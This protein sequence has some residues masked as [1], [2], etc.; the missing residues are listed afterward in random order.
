M[1]LFQLVQQRRRRIEII[2]QAAG[3][4]FI[5]CPTGCG[6]LVRISRL[7][8][9][10][11]GHLLDERPAPEN[12]HAFRAVLDQGRRLAAVTLQPAHIADATRRLKLDANLYR[13]S[14]AEAG[15]R[16]FEFRRRIRTHQGT[17]EE[18][19]QDDSHMGL[20]DL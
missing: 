18:Q 2:G 16:E 19:D 9:A 15:Q 17:G 5:H 6:R 12:P 4:Q 10:L 14:A 1:G 3:I 20:S 13:I 7:D 8:L 11:P